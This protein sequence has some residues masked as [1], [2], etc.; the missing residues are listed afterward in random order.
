VHD[1]GAKA[2]GKAHDRGLKD[3]FMSI[4][5]QVIPSTPCSYGGFTG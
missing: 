2:L 5:M 4:N 1:I 3:L